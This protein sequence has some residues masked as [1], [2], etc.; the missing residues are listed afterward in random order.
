MGKVTLEWVIFYGFL[1][2]KLIMTIKTGS[3]VKYIGEPNRWTYT[4]DIT[5]ELKGR[6]VNATISGEKEFYRV[7]FD[8]G[9]NTTIEIN[10]LEKIE[11][12]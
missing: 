1:K 8:N 10:H 2:A 12:E 6:V 9:V 7:E 11:N 3:R 5:P 4:G